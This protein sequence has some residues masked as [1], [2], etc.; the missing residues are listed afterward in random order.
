MP[1]NL[2]TFQLK[3][4]CVGDE[5]ENLALSSVAQQQFGHAR[6]HPSP[7][8]LEPAQHCCLLAFPSFPALCS[9]HADPSKDEAHVGHQVTGHSRFTWAFC[10]PDLAG[11]IPT[12]VVLV[13]QSI[14]INFVHSF[15]QQWFWRI[16]LRLVGSSRN[17][18]SELQTIF[19]TGLGF[20]LSS[21]P[22]ASLSFTLAQ[23]IIFFPD[24]TWY[25]IYFHWI[26]AL[27]NTWWSK[28]QRQTQEHL[29]YVFLSSRFIISKCTV[30]WTGSSA[31]LG[32]DN[33]FLPFLLLFFTI[34]K[35]CF[36]S[37]WKLLSCFTVF[38]MV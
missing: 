10:H 21:F 1:L 30:G 11:G 3:P 27:D 9:K 16:F 28:Y 2:L 24:D 22:S 33:M 36:S 25:I 37:H 4:L 34:I 23:S 31:R 12:V 35:F 14:T 19:L 8:S 18:R 15:H 38:P 5:P 13:S 32:I 6:R 7:M 17:Q 29:E 26:T 20:I